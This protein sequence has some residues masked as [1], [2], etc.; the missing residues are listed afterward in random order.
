VNIF[1]TI[2]SIASLPAHLKAALSRVG[3][4]FNEAMC[5]LRNSLRP[6]K[7]Y[8]DYDSLYGASNCS[9][10]S[11]GR[12]PSAYAN[13]N[14][15]SLMQMEKGPVELNSAAMASVSVLNRNDPVLAPMPIQ[16][17]GRHVDVINNGIKVSN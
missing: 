15:F 6:R 10:T 14:A 17:M 4:A 12:G 8:D 13:M 5:I 16:E 1:R 11:G 2:S 9:S 3:S 7:T